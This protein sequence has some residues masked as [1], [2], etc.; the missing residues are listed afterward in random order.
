[1][2]DQEFLASYAVEIDEAGVARLQSVLEDNR[3]LA[4]SLSSAFQQ[5]WADLDTYVSY[6]AE[7]SVPAPVQNRADAAPAAAEM[8]PVLSGQLPLALVSPDSLRTEAVSRIRDPDSSASEIH[9][10][11]SG[12]GEELQSF[13]QDIAVSDAEI[14]AA[15]D[16]TE[17]SKE[18][19]SF[20]TS[21]SETDAALPLR[22][23]RTRADLSL[24]ELQRLLRQPLSLTAD[25]SAVISAASSALSAIRAAYASSPLQLSASIVSSAIAG[26]PDASAAA[27]AGTPASSVSRSVEAP[28]NITVNA[29]GTD[30][31]ALGQSIYNSAQRYLVKT[32]QQ[33]L[34]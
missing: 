15:L 14:P 2:P 34:Q 8:R 18:L 21:L 13:L 3:S 20:Q 12:A 33:T 25:T 32:L 5:A 1:M 10:D 17:A 16:L 30:S 28:V 4:E 26:L 19:T 27:A 31:R 23:D 24:S 6:A 7:T 9:L 22:L 29:S 11:L